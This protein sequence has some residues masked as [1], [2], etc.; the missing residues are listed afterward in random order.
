MTVQCLKII[1]VQNSRTWRSWMLRVN[2][3]LTRREKLPHLDQSR[4]H[5]YK[6][7]SVLFLICKKWN[8][9]EKYQSQIS[10]PLNEGQWSRMRVPLL[11]VAAPRDDFKSVNRGNRGIHRDS[12]PLGTIQ[13]FCISF[14]FKNMVAVYLLRWALSAAG[15][16]SLWLTQA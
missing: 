7:I 10:S 12:V 2:L 8:K 14:I 1:G 4:G 3:G 6:E 15:F 13:K 5:S 16:S 11:L 9:S